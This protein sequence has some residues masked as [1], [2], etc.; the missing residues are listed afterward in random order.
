MSGSIPAKT[1]SVAYSSERKHRFSNLLWREMK[2]IE[3]NTSVN[4][5]THFA[6]S[7][8]CSVFIATWKRRS[9]ILGQHYVLWILLLLES[10]MARFFVTTP[11]IL[12][13][14]TLFIPKLTYTFHQIV[15]RAIDAT[16]AC[17]RKSYSTADQLYVNTLI[18]FFAFSFLPMFFFLSLCHPS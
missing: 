2:D 6:N 9:E 4:T 8:C 12:L 3:L 5:F 15:T 13:F 16:K 1:P 11:D 17:F 10:Y 7:R 14:R 18:S